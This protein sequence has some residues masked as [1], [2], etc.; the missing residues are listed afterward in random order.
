MCVAW[1]GGGGARAAADGRVNATGNLAGTASECGNLS[2][3]SAMPGSGAVIAGVAQ[4]GLWVTS[5][6]GGSW[7]P[8]GTGPGSAAITN[9]PAWISY[10]PLSAGVF[11]EAGIYNGGGAFRTADGG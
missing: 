7:Q 5:D 10:D 9:R 1:L 4:K 11:Y 6:G 3:V 2:L 8:L